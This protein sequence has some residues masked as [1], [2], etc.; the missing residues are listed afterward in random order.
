MDD[1]FPNFQFFGECYTMLRNNRN[2]NAGGLM[3]YVN[4]GILGKLINSYDHKKGA[5]I[6]VF[7]F[8]IS[9]KKLFLLGNYKPP[10]PSENPNFKNLPNSFDLESLIKSQH[11]INHYHPLL[12]LI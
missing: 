8:S 4:E 6:I 2:K 7:E 10:L 9:N 3:L 11:V 5:E 12:V 1:S